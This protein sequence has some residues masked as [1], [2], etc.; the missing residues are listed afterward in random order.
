MLTYP[1]VTWIRDSWD[2]RVFILWTFDAGCWMGVKRG[3]RAI[4]CVDVVGK[5][6]KVTVDA[7]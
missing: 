5:R 6:R 3:V 2:L 4:C 1:V 7:R